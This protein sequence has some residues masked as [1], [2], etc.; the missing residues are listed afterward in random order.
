MVKSNN[1]LTLAILCRFHVN[2]NAFTPIC[3]IVPSM[4]PSEVVISINADGPSLIRQS[5]GSG[6][7]DAYKDMMTP[8][9][10]NYRM[11]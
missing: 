2:D 1:Y 3:S 4:I 10:M 6:S 11:T 7:A 8:F 5:R 9:P